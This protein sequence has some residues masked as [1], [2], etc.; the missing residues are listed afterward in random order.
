MRVLRNLWIRWHKT[1]SPKKRTK[2]Q[3]L[4]ILIYIKSM[5]FDLG[6]DVKREKNLLLLKSSYI[7][8]DKLWLWLAMS[9]SSNRN[10]SHQMKMIRLRLWTRLRVKCV[11]RS[12]TCLKTKFMLY[13]HQNQFYFWQ[14]WGGLGDWQQPLGESTVFRDKF[15]PELELMNFESNKTSFKSQAPIDHL[16]FVW[17]SNAV[18]Y[19]DSCKC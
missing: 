15:G 13:N 1:W 9:S 19:E 16:Y 2:I 14:N 17:H 4:S 7:V 11:Q 18:S 8:T 3:N 12:F 10:S 5:C 6:K